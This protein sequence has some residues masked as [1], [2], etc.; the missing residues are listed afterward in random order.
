MIDEGADIIEIGGESTG[1]GS[2]DVSQKEEIARTIDI[3]KAIKSAYP[4]QNLSIDTYKSVV[5]SEAIKA[6]VMMVNDIT[7]GRGDDQM[8]SVIADADVDY[9]LM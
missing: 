3:I 5:A 1:P 9:V 4:N 2:K 8:F 7:A 6:G